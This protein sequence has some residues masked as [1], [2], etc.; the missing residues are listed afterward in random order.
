VVAPR[1]SILMFL[2]AFSLAI[3]AC[4]GAEANS[5]SSSSSSSGGESRQPTTAAEDATRQGER[6]GDREGRSRD[7]SA[8]RPERD[9]GGGGGQREKGSAVLELSGDDRTGFSGVCRV[10]EAETEL[11]GTVPKTVNLA[12]DGEPLECR[13]ENTGPG[14][15]KADLS[16][17]G[18]HY[19]QQTSSGALNFALSGDGYTS[20]TSS[21]T[22]VE[23]ETPDA[24]SDA[25][26][27]AEAGSPDEGE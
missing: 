21:V 1:T 10:G 3:S 8:S 27:R 18:A 22:A 26:A 2:V 11:E 20:S 14:S 17:G 15:L 6:D 16:V 13:I 23:N 5:S 12:L 9:G 19:V 25:S 4:G 7:R 24:V